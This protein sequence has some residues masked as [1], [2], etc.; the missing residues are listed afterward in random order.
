L[1][2]SR[3]FDHQHYELLNSSRGAVVSRLLH[4]LKVPLGLRTAI[5]VGCGLG[6]F[7]G[8]LR[9]LGLEIMGVDGRQQN[10]KEAQRRNPDIRFARFDAED[11]SLRTLG[12]FD[13]VFCFGL[14][15]HLENPLLTIRHLYAM[16]KKLL[17]V[18][19]VIFPGDEPIMGLIDE[20][21]HDDQGLNHVA[22]YPT[23]ACLIKMLFRVGFPYVY[24]FTQQPDHADYNETSNSR[25]VR[26]M[27][28]ASLTPIISKQL[29][30]V[31]E[32]HSLIQP[33][34]VK[35]GLAPENAVQK[36]KRFVDKPLPEKM[37]SIRR[38]IKTQ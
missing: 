27:L 23:E 21:W 29:A 5:D 26:T 13:L 14:L 1:G 2:V 8:L 38:I 37:K 15:Y 32:P 9:S 12:I 24:E 22:F 7:S 19:A 36:L 31:R 3:I 11:P 33:W 17:F 20:A 10:V 34:D 30:L 16:T 28:A 6:F 18:E 35:S 4:E 25:R